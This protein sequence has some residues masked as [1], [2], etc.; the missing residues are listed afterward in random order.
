MIAQK[1][2]FQQN[3]SPAKPKNKST[4][5]TKSA[6]KCGFPPMDHL[7]ARERSRWEKQTWEK[8]GEDWFINGILQKVTS[9]RLKLDRESFH[10]DGSLK[11]HWKQSSGGAQGSKSAGSNK[12]TGSG[13]GNAAGKRK[14][15]EV[16]ID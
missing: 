6:T 3:V 14:Y 5:S 12:S 7:T 16:M 8:R 13:K 15:D 4:K 11:S 2:T 10:D 1:T 9:K